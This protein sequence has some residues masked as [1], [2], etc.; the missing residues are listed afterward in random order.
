MYN[1]CSKNMVSWNMVELDATY[2]IWSEV[3]ISNMKFVKLYA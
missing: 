3:P 1:V 2:K